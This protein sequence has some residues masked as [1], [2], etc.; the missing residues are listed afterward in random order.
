MRE[1]ATR[2]LDA[3]KGRAEESRQEELAACAC[4]RGRRH[5]LAVVVV[6]EQRVFEPVAAAERVP[7]MAVTTASPSSTMGMAVTTASSSPTMGMAVGVWVAG[8]AL[9][10]SSTIHGVVESECYGRVCRYFLPQAFSA[11]APYTLANPTHVVAAATALVLVIVLR[12][13]WPPVY[14][15]DSAKKS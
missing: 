5:A 11:Y 10:L 7:V 3:K 8:C 6:A 13:A 15:T 12:K 1:D 9:A 4:S 14:V 2:Y